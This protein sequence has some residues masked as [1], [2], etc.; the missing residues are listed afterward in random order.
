MSFV[1]SSIYD[2]DKFTTLFEYMCDDDL[3]IIL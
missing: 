2:L 3:F 1:F